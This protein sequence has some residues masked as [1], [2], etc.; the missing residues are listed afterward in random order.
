MATFAAC[1]RNAFVFTFLGT[2]ISETPYITLLWMNNA[3]FA[4]TAWPIFVVI[5]TAEISLVTGLCTVLE[6]TLI[7][8]IYFACFG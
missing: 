6:P 3:S 2:T 7:N 4:G 1:S 5:I 8:T